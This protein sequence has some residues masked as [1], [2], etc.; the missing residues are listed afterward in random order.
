MMTLFFFFFKASQLYGSHV[1]QFDHDQTLYMATA[2]PMPFT[3][4]HNTAMCTIPC[5]ALNALQCVQQKH[6]Q[7]CDL[8]LS[9]AM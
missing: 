1:Q 3:R 4:L 7:H 5:L 8:S 6:V 2:A 9:V